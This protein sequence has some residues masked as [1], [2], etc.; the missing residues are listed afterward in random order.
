MHELWYVGEPLA[1]R[2]VGGSPG[3]K[4]GGEWVECF[5]CDADAC[6]KFHDSIFIAVRLVLA[7]ALRPPSVICVSKPG[8]R[9]AALVGSSL[10]DITSYSRAAYHDACILHLLVQFRPKYDRFE[11]DTRIVDGSTSA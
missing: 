10:P 1:S 8:D 5:L 4:E 6:K 2:G 3:R 11:R 9:N 7:V